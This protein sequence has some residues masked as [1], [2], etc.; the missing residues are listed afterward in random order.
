MGQCVHHGAEKLGVLAGEAERF[1]VQCEGLAQIRADRVAALKGL[2]EE[3]AGERAG[4][5]GRV[6]RLGQRH[7]QRADGQQDGEQQTEQT[8]HHGGVPFLYGRWGNLTA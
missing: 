2:K 8:F 3:R 4:P 7:R 1:G 6:L 5:V